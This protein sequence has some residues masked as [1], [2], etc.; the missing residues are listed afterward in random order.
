LAFLETRQN[1]QG[2][3]GFNQNAAGISVNYK[4]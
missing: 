4:F 2:Q 3:L 1:Y